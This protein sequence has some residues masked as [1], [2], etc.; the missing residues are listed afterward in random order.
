LA[1]KGNTAL[2]HFL[3]EPAYELIVIPKPALNGGFVCFVQPAI[4][5]RIQLFDII[6][7]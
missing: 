5:I 6:S 1:F 7:R 3:K 4:F 2:F